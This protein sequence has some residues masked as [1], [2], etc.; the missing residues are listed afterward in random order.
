MYKFI[1]IEAGC[2]SSGYSLSKCEEN[3]NK[4]AS[5]GFDLVQVYQTSTP[6]CGSTN[7]SLVMVF[8]K[9]SA[10]SKVS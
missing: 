4:M 8:K 10:T 5:N 2:C 9:R 3:A 7:S 1:I 6:G